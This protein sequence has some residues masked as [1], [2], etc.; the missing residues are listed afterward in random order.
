MRRIALLVMM[1]GLFAVSACSEPPPSPFAG[2]QSSPVLG[3]EQ[4]IYTSCFVD[5]GLRVAVT[6]SHQVYVQLTLPGGIV[7][8]D[9]T[10]LDSFGHWTFVSNH[11]LPA[12]SCYS[13]NLS[14]NLGQGP[15]TFYPG[16]RS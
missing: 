16:W 2:Y 14:D 4:G 11:S 1:A 7:E 8:A 13:M 10:V 12:G 15:F 6:V 3:V 5:D 9:T